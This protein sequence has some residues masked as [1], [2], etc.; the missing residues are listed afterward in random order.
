MSGTTSISPTS[1]A[2]LNRYDLVKSGFLGADLPWLAELRDESAATFKSLGLP[3]PRVEDWKYTNLKALDKIVLDRDSAKDVTGSD[4]PVQNGSGARLVFVNG[5]YRED[6]S[7]VAGLSG[8]IRLCSVGGLLKSDKDLVQP[9][10]SYNDDAMPLLALNGAFQEDGY[11]LIL[12][13]GVQADELIEVL[14]VHAGDVVSY[15]RNIISVG[16]NAKVRL[17]ETH[18]GTGNSTGFFNGATL[19]TVGEG[20]QVEHLRYQMQGSGTVHVNTIRAE[21]AA[22]G[23]YNSF[24][25]SEGGQM[26]RDEMRVALM[27][28]EASTKLHGVYLGSGEQVLDNTTV[29]RHQAPNTKSEENY[30]GALKDKSRGVFQGN[31]LV[32]KDADGTDGRMSNK[33]IL[34]TGEAEIN[35]KPQLEIYADDVQCAHGST[36]GELDEEALFYLRSRGIP[37]SQA[38][39]VLVEGF[40]NEVMEE[41]GLSDLGGA[42]TA[43][44][45]D[46]MEA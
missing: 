41:F 9:A 18:M 31:I 43:K 19:A 45:S 28:K 3:T 38:K 2:L 22:R 42:F 16:A 12:D 37:E 14:H 46:W 39:T 11:V 13:S 23:R 21:V 35:S 26:A 20:G 5:H 4:L 30:R 1:Q 24:I 25:L 15:P 7:C 44:I 33:T 10:L 40:L 6:L 27:E 34:L 29:I 36:A 17:L 32:E 8:G